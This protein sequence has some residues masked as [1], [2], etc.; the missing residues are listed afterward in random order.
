M[1][2]CCVSE[3]WTGKPESDKTFQYYLHGGAVSVAGHGHIVDA[4]FDSNCIFAD[5]ALLISG[6]YYGWELGRSAEYGGAVYFDF[7]EN[8]DLLTGWA[9]KV[10]RSTFVH[11]EVKLWV[12]A[13]L[14][15]FLSLSENQLCSYLTFCSVSV[16]WV[17]EQPYLM[18]RKDQ[19]PRKWWT[20]HRMQGGGVGSVGREIVLLDCVFDSNSAADGGA[21]FINS[22]TLGT[23]QTCTF[24]GNVA[25]EPGIFDADLDSPNAQSARTHTFVSG[26]GGSLVLYKCN[27]FNC[28]FVSNKAGQHHDSCT[29][30]CNSGGAVEGKD[31]T[32]SNCSF[33]GNQ[34]ARAGG[35]VK[36]AGLTLN[37][38][39]FR[40]NR[41]AVA[42]GAVHCGPGLSLISSCSFVSNQ[43]GVM[44]GD[45]IYSAHTDGASS[46][47]AKAIGTLVRGSSFHNNGQQRGYLNG[48][49][50]F[51]EG[52]SVLQLT[53]NVFSAK[54][55]VADGASLIL[56]DSQSSSQGSLKWVF[57]PVVNNV[58][59]VKI[60]KACPR[61]STGPLEDVDMTTLSESD[62]LGT[63]TY[64][65][66]NY[67]PVDLCCDGPKRELNDFVSNTW[68]RR[69]S[70]Q[71][72]CPESYEPCCTKCN[73]DKFTAF[74]T[75]LARAGYCIA[76]KPG[77]YSLSDECEFCPVGMFSH[78]AVATCKHC[79]P[80]RV[81]AHVG[82]VACLTCAAGTHS[83]EDQTACL[84]CEKGSHSSGDAVACTV[85]QA[86]MASAATD[87]AC[88]HCFP[89]QYA[90]EDKQERCEACPPGFWQGTPGASSCE[91]CEACIAGRA[92]SVDC[93]A[94]TD[95][96]CVS[97][98]AGTFSPSN[99]NGKCEKCPKGFSQ[100]SS[101]SLSCEACRNPSTYCGLLGSVA[102]QEVAP[103]F[104]SVGN[105]THGYTG[106]QPCPEGFSCDG[107]S[108][109]KKE[110]RDA[111]RYCPPQTASALLVSAGYYT[112]PEG[113]ETLK[114]GERECNVSAREFCADGRRQSC[115]TCSGGQFQVL[116][117]TEQADSVCSVC[118]AG[119]FTAGMNHLPACHLCPAGHS[120]AVVGSSECAPCQDPATY[121]RGEGSVNPQVVSSGFYSLPRLLNEPRTEQI[122]CEA[123]FYCVS[124][125]R[126]KCSDTK[127]YC[128][129]G[130]SEP[131]Q[132]SA[133]FHSSGNE[134]HGNAEQV[135]CPAGY[136]VSKLPNRFSSFL[137]LSFRLLTCFTVDCMH[138]QCDGESGVKQ[139]CRDSRYFCPAQ[140]ASALLPSAGWYT[141]PEGEETLKTGQA[142]CNVTAR[143]FCVDGRRQKM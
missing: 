89:G 68:R 85:C 26:D 129:A 31:S 8:E 19:S 18:D 2:C 47:T 86:G 87:L 76:C 28:F 134:T 64:G 48:C 78:G 4:V 113:E 110:C 20:E 84:P 92:I 138:M 41:A 63:S 51:A 137:F 104:Y 128:P 12:S 45:A 90:A 10:E 72:D 109:V 114:T 13:V 43:A 24:R 6:M 140:T 61:G 74:T 56:G 120:Q 60:Q 22:V 36:G 136:Y 11:N 39:V 106:Q 127:T 35:A 82:S 32:F 80:G 102:P 16:A 5:G 103:Q 37:N 69:A 29:T 17:R 118:G 83:N 97:C 7:D 50:I 49:D 142:E 81:T 111:R 119:T 42:G 124:G 58:S 9:N 126:H 52:S 70:K 130:S 115:K 100:A 88:Q 66:G 116:S 94:F 91:L 21:A 135:A 25:V 53:A 131:L 73:T 133:Q 122:R 101:E 27:V 57:P 62:P 33:V 143:E 139:A 55:I 107:V 132:V 96:K 67:Y 117:C 38:C 79:Q 99:N 44:L 15:F 98:Q 23:L 3:Q 121:C 65:Y 34:A 30:A 77:T 123:G 93:S 141:I 105:A 14:S 46:S 75:Q 54:V 108:G 40:A 95:R 71:K 1:C 59:T 112:V 125:L